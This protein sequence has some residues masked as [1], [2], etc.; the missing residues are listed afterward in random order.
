MG[1]KML[2]PSPQLMDTEDEIGRLVDICMNLPTDPASIFIS[3]RG[4]GQDP[5]SLLVTT[6]RLQPFNQTFVII[7]SGPQEGRKT[8][9]T[10]GHRHVETIL[11]TILENPRIPNLFFDVRAACTVLRQRHQIPLAGVIDIQLLER[12]TRH[13]HDRQA[14]VKSLPK[15]VAFGSGVDREELESWVAAKRR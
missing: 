15:C 11:K 5:N 6:I 8:L 2:S 3:L 13:E 14:P 9:L 10:P 12:G 1:I 7:P 4:I